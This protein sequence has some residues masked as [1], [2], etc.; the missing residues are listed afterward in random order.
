MVALADN[1]DMVARLGRALSTDETAAV[2]GLLTEASALVV[3]YLRRDWDALTDVPGA[4]RVVV[5]RMAARA[6]TGASNIPAGAESYG[7][8]LSVMSHTVKLGPDVVMGSVWL[9]RV[10]KTTLAPYVRRPS[11]MNFPMY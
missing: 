1:A 5:S 9:S 7:S 6:L 3:G 10:D 8:S 4:V 2:G 11:V